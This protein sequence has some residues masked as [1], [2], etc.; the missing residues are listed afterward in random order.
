MSDIYDPS[1]LDYNS[2]SGKPLNCPRSLL[3]IQILSPKGET[4]TS[5]PLLNMT[6]TGNILNKDITKNLNLVVKINNQPLPALNGHIIE[7]EDLQ[8]PLIIHLN[9][10]D[11]ITDMS[12]GAYS[13]TV[14]AVARN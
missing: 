12:H 11:H 9:L 1:R 10:L 3:S 8:Q 14:E 2:I 4:I 5:S 7:K 13:I 6:I